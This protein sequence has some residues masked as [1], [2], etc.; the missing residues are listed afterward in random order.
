[1]V[2]LIAGSARTPVLPLLIASGDDYHLARLS[3]AGVKTPPP[4]KEDE[5]GHHH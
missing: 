3:L 5:S 1:M 4:I 2:D